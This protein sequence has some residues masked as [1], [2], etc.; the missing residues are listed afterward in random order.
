[1]N[2]SGVENPNMGRD[3]VFTV[4]VTL[5]AKEADAYRFM[6][7]EDGTELKSSDGDIVDDAITYFSGW[8]FDATI[9][10]VE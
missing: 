4:K 9:E 6:V 2:T 3:L 10:S 7:D 1:M 8:H 5:P